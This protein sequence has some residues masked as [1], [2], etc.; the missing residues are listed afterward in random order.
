MTDNLDIIYLFGYSS[1][2]GRHLE[3]LFPILYLQKAK[4]SKIGLVLIHDGVIGITTKGNIPK[5]MKNLLDLNIAL[6]AMIPD[7]KARGIALEYINEKI[8]LIEYDVL[9][10]ILDTTSKIISWM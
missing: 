10:D 2:T 8:K 1:N 7:L 4:N 6:F 9:I 3:R 5:Q